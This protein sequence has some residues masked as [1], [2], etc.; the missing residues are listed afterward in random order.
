MIPVPIDSPEMDAER[1]MLRPAGDWYGR[2]AR[3]PEWESDFLDA[4]IAAGSIIETGDP[5]SPA[6]SWGRV[7]TVI[8]FVIAVVA[9]ASYP[10]WWLR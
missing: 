5:I 1:Q 4:A 3:G 7:L 2:K 8:A 6:A 10:L 9:V